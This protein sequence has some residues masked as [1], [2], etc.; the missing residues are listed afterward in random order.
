MDVR[1]LCLAVL[2]HGDASGY[3][4]KKALEEGPYAH[5]YRA[6]FGSIYPALAKLAEARL[7]TAR[8]EEQQKRP[9]KKVY[10]LTQ[11]GRLELARAL[12]AAPVGPDYLR[13]P[14][15]LVL[16]QADLLLPER[17]RALVDA[18]IA[19]LENWV[20]KLSAKSCPEEKRYQGAGPDFVCGYGLAV[21]RAELEYL[22]AHRHRVEE[23]AD[24]LA[25]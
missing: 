10:R 22:R 23:A 11:A 3:E 19:W 8:E 2:A 18:R 14:F 20:E 17:C 24:S 15:L 21:Y 1:T 16:F 7:V 9:D 12:N 4:I 13:S 6:S 25:A 5:F